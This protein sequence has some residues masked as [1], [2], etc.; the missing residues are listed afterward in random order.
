MNALLFSLAVQAEPPLPYTDWIS[1]AFYK[2]LWAELLGISLQPGSAG[3]LSNMGET[4]LQAELDYVVSSRADG[5]ASSHK[6]V[7]VSLSGIG[8]QSLRS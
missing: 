3:A 7:I 4:C 1:P 2:E 8:V 5:S 6:W